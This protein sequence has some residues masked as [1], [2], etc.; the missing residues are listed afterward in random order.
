MCENRLRIIEYRRS[1]W[2]RFCGNEMGKMLCQDLALASL[3]RL[4]R[5][6]N[7]A[8]AYPILIMFA[9]MQINRRMV[10]IR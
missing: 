2:D 10:E 4:C 6:V 7:E 9:L 8:I 3:Y 5:I 1:D